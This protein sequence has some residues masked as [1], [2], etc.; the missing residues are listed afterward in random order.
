MAPPRRPEIVIG[1]D[2]GK[3]S[4]WACVATR[5]AEVLASKS[6]DRENALDSL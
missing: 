3:S 2:A 6:V 1:L 4:H 5:D